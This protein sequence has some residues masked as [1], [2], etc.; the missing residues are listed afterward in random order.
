MPTNKS[1][2]FIWEDGQ[3]LPSDT[4]L[5]TWIQDSILIPNCWFTIFSERTWSDFAILIPGET[6]SS[7]VA[8]SFRKNS[9]VQGLCPVT[10]ALHFFWPKIGTASHRV[11]TGTA[12]GK[13]WLLLL[14][15]FEV[16]DGSDDSSLLWQSRARTHPHS[17]HLQPWIHKILWMWSSYA[18]VL[19]MTGREWQH[20]CRVT[21]AF[22]NI[23]FWWSPQVDSLN[24]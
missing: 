15:R 19:T 12:Q 11:E 6:F 7:I 1:M 10:H 24:F 5:A 3:D 13:Q 8:S 21:K 23:A 18:P 22:P 9:D 14:L 2:T 17:R 20:S 4:C 16:Q